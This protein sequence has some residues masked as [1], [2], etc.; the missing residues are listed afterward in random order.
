MLDT[1]PSGPIEDESV[2]IENE[3]VNVIVHSLNRTKGG[4]V[5]DDRKEVLEIGKTVQRLIDQLS[6]IY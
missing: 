3:I 1:V 5:I 4:F 2:E 6:K